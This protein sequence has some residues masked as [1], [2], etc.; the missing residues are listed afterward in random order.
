MT[1]AV[2]GSP[3]DC[4][5]SQNFSTH[6]ETSRRRV[7]QY[8]AL[9]AGHRHHH[10]QREAA[11][12]AQGPRERGQVAGIRANHCLGHS[13]VNGDF[14]ASLAKWHSPS[15]DTALLDE[16]LNDMGLGQCESLLEALPRGS[17]SAATGPLDPLVTG[18][19]SAVVEQ[20]AE[21]VAANPLL[22]RQLQRAV[23]GREHPPKPV[24]MLP[25]Q[26][27]HYFWERRFWQGLRT[28]RPV[29]RALRSADAWA[30]RLPASVLVSAEDA[31]EFRRLAHYAL[32][33]HLV[34]KAMAADLRLAD[35][36]VETLK[37][38]IRSKEGWWKH[39]SLF[40]QAKLLTV[41]VTLSRIA[42]HRKE[43][44]IPATFGHIGLPFNIL[45]AVLQVQRPLCGVLIESGC[46]CNGVSA[47]FL[48]NRLLA[49]DF[50]CR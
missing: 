40:E 27:G 20:V 22:L 32:I 5:H 10:A 21:N 4:S 25:P 28:W 43:R 9:R 44:S 14:L 46:T 8:A 42:T 15:L 24:L 35:C 16:Y 33:L 34:T 41:E 38:E 29:R 1:R 7:V 3:P 30:A 50:C 31:E 13:S 36:V 49:F 6:N 18:G 2:F 12:H 37:K 11:S 26:R 17:V 48:L 45:E 47:C 39:L 19:I 23:Y